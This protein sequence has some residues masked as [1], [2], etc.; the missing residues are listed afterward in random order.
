[1]SEG[2]TR[3]EL[4]QE[5]SME[6]WWPRVQDLGIPLPETVR[7]EATKEPIMDGMELAVPDKSDVAEAVRQVGGPPAFIRSD[8]TA[9]K[10]QM[11]NGSKVTTDDP[12]EMMLGSLYEAHLGFGAPKPSCYYVRE[13]LDL[14]HEFR[15]FANSET[16]VAAEVRTFILDGEY[17]DGEFYWPEDAIWDHAATEDDWPALL[18]KTRDRAMLDKGIWKQMSE[19]VATE[20]DTG[21]WSV[22]FAL[23]DNGTWYLLDMARGELSWHPDSVE[24]PFTEAR[25]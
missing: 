22:D 18:E 17:Y 2:A 7:L 12:E 1:M 21:Y 9:S 3:E 10:H 13:W 6:N 8:Q 5:C 14:Y 11:G 25:P 19:T 16:P 24:K 15:S 4:M 20:F 23:G